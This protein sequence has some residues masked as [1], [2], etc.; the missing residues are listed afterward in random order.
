MI[1][2]KEAL[3]PVDIG[4]ELIAHDVDVTAKIIRLGTEGIILEC[5]F[6]LIDENR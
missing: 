2:R 3:A 4:A 1:A 5:P 6:V